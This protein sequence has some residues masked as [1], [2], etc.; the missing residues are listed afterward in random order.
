MLPGT[1]SRLSVII[2]EFRYKTC[3]DEAVPREYFTTVAKLRSALA[4]DSLRPGF[5]VAV[6]NGKELAIGPA[7]APQAFLFDFEFETLKAGEG[8]PAPGKS[9][10]RK[11]FDDRD[12]P[13]AKAQRTSGRYTFA[14]GEVAFARGSLADL[15][16]AVLTYLEKSRP[17][18]LSK[19]SM[20][21]KR[22]RR[23]VARN[24]RD[25]FDRVHLAEKH[26]RRIDGGWWMGTNNSAG[27]TKAWIRRA[28]DTAGIDFISDIVIGF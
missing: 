25:L 6:R 14:H 8:T 2:S 20:T 1:L 4:A 21:K 28:C 7:A 17:G 12:L 24:K 27:E 16:E 26:A 23:I 15:L 11:R 3:K 10:A 13:A 19:L 18:T 22:T 5:R 9:A